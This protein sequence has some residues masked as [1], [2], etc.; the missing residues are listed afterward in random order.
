MPLCLTFYHST[1]RPEPI[2]PSLLR[3]PHDY[4]ESTVFSSGRWRL[5]NTT[6]HHLNT[7]QFVLALFQSG[8]G[9]KSARYVW[10][11]TGELHYDHNTEEISPGRA[12]LPASPCWWRQPDCPISPCWWHQP[13]CPPHPVGG[14]SM[15]AHLTLL[16]AAAWLPTSPCW[17]QQPDCRPLHIGGNSLT[18]GLALLSSLTAHL[19]LLVTAAWLP[20]AHLTLLVAPAW[21]PISRCWWQQPDCRSLPVGDSS[22]TAGL[23]LLVAAAWLP[24]SPFWWQQPDCRPRPV[25]GT[26][27]TAGL[28][29]LVEPAWLP[30]S[31]C[32]WHQP[33]CRPRP[34]EQP[35]CPPHPV[36][37]NSL[38]AGLSLLVSP[39][40]LPASPRWCSTSLT[41]GLALLVAPA[42]LQ[43]RSVGGTSLTAGLALLVQHQPARA[44]PLIFSGGS[45]RRQGGQPT[46]KCPKNRKN[47]GFWPLHPRIW[48][49]TLPV[50]KSAG[51]GCVELMPGEVLK[52]SN[53]YSQ[54][55]LSYW[56]KTTRGPFEP[57]PIRSWDIWSASRYTSLLSH[58]PFTD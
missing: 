16:V 7:L 10:I 30:A 46:P 50:F 20:G 48:G 34:A 21:L 17:W 3:L 8:R 44:S 1:F 32:W 11:A 15:T 52:I 4:R 47:I 57:T 14:S 54:P 33:D 45:N 51:S 42:W 58:I 22:L 28:S 19:T 36:G 35:V 38:T 27:L 24:A 26:S 49:S 23:T 40:W 9:F 5:L 25:G 31:P 41:A 56:R 37:G 43:P 39:A 18:T 55:N 29:L 12:W 53:R 6:I 2:L 13:D